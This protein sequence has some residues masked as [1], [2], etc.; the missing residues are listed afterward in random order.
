MPRKGGSI[1]RI[2]RLNENYI[3]HAT[4]ERTGICQQCGQVFAQVWRPSKGEDGQGEYTHFKTCPACRM[5]NANG[6]RKITIPYTPHPTQQKVHDSTARFKCLNCGNRWG[7]DLCSIAEG[8]LKF[9]SME[10]EDRS[11]DVN[12]PVLFWIVAPSLTYARQNWRDLKKLLPVDIVYNI[13]LSNLTIE[14]INGGII[15]VH[16]A[17]DP[18][19]LV[20][21]GLDIVTVTEAARVRELDIVWA[22]LRQRLDSPGRGPGGKGGHAIINSTPRGKK[23]YFYQMYQ[24]GIKNSPIYIPEWESFHFTTWDNPHMA[25]KRYT[26]VGHDANGNPITFE[27]AIKRSMSERRYRQDYLAEFLDEADSV[28][29]KAEKCAV[30]L[31]TPEDVAEWEKVEPFEVYTIGYDP[32]KSIDNAV[33][34]VRNS[35]A[36]VVKIDVMKGK[37]WDYQWDMVAS[38]ARKYNNAKV[39]FGK[40]GIGETI[41]SQLEKRGLIV[42]AVHETPAVKAAMIERLSVLIEQEIIS[43][44]YDEYFLFELMDYEYIDKGNRTV[45]RNATRD[46]HDDCVSA[47]AF[48]FFNYDAETETLPWVGLLS[49]IDKAG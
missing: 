3:K 49:G 19:S 27:E 4:S 5:A 30:R 40:T 14:T 44:P 36:R 41:Q 29:P 23:N 17:D 38:Y 34:I 21:V 20:G 37:S 42:E 22:N 26:I 1:G 43:Y 2:D 39:I 33:I 46:S 24:M 16:S 13:S 32:G 6:Y 15:E 35:S 28:F 7:K 45:Y 31:L 25:K 48:A 8:V 11:I 10:C 12:P 47:L 9:I 18:E